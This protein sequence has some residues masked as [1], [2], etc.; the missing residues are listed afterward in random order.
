METTQ[1]IKEL[2]AQARDEINLYGMRSATGTKTHL[3]GSG[4]GQAYCGARVMPY[5]TKFTEITCD[6]CAKHIEGHSETAWVSASKFGFT[7]KTGK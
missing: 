2:Q 3:G 7:V 1:D 6:K 5:A 4:G